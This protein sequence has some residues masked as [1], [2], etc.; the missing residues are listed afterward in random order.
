MI[1]IVRHSATETET[2]PADLALALAVAG[3]VSAPV[4]RAPE[5]VTAPRR[6]TARARRSSVRG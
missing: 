2:G 4:T 6:R 3:A 5:V 1:R